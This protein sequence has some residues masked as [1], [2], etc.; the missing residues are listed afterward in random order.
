MNV[1]HNGFNEARGQCVKNV[2]VEGAA[3]NKLEKSGVV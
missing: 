1:Q 3:A 2:S